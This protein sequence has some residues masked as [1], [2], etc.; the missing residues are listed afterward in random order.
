MTEEK[1]PKKKGGCLI[2]CGTVILGFIILGSIISVI[3]EQQN[4]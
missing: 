4:E 1:K 3:E 2:G